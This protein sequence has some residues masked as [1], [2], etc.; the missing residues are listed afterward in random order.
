MAPN[1]PKFL[2]VLEIESMFNGSWWAHENHKG[3]GGFQEV[4]PQCIFT[5]TIVT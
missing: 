5:H 2:E 1:N 3:E 4:Q